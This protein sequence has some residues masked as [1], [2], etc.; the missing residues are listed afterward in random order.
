MHHAG[1][2]AVR[3]GEAES[4]QAEGLPAAAGDREENVMNYHGRGMYQWDTWYCK[5]KDTEEVHAFYLQEL[6]PGSERT[7]RE[8]DSLGHA[9]SRN[10]IDW[11][12]LPPAIEPAEPG[13]PGDLTAWT[14]STVEHDGRYYMYYTIRSSASGGKVQAI[15]LAVSD[16]LTTWRKR[17]DNPVLTPDPRWYN[18]EERPSPN[19]IVDCRD[20]MVVKHDRRP[21]WFGVFATRIPTE[22][23]P[24][25]SVFAGAY[26]EDLVHWEQTPP[27]FQSPDNRY[28]IVEMP[29]LFEIDG[30][31]YLTFL[32]DT[33]YGNRE[34][35]GDL[36]LTCGTRYAVAD[37]LEGPYVEPEDNLLIASMGF[38]G[39]SCRT[40][41]FKGKKYMLYTSNERTN[42]SEFK[43]TFG[44][45][46]L[47]K[48]IRLVDG[49]LRACYADLVDGKLG[50]RLIEKGVLPE[51]ISLRNDH[52]TM[53]RWSVDGTA[54]TGSVRTAWCRYSFAPSG[55]SFV[56]EAELSLSAGVAAGLVFRQGENKS[57]L[58]ALLDYKRQE[59]ML[60]TVPRF[61]IADRRAVAL[62][63]D[64]TYQVK[65]VANGPFIEV[66]IDE[67]L[68]LQLV[69][70]YADEGRFGLLL[71]R[72]E[73]RFD[74][75]RAAELINS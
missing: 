56:Y 8:A 26:S 9:V 24:E 34:V 12:E 36:H 60:C 67:V 51:G 11:E 29:D 31:W 5:R 73:G 15:G 16:D 13:E 38:N 63:Y 62:E 70:Y 49:K 71:D 64:C 57:G 6:R 27:V 52:E 69:S 44:S 22:E 74:G 59:V 18:T 25:G 45:L 65:V 1:A 43:H 2:G 32:E 68:Y 39:I 42:E 66:Y 50:R 40:V 17:E 19:G 33:A 10:L 72:A 35:L 58:V 41:D 14:G 75:V 3:Q 54:A 55:S 4:G 30:R 46:S 20:L 21:G 37:R 61:Q 7:R 28:S 47:P 23:L 48:E 53:G